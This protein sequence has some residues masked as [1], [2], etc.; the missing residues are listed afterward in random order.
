MKKYLILS[1]F[2]LKISL[3]FAQ[4]HRE[5]FVEDFSTDTN[6]W[7]CGVDQNVITSIHDGYY[8]IQGVTNGQGWEWA[9]EF[10]PYSYSNFN[11]QASFTKLGGKGYY[12]MSFGHKDYKYYFIIGEN[13]T[14]TILKRINNYTST[15]KLWTASVSIRELRGA[16]NDLS[17]RRKD[18]KL[19]FYINNNAVCSIIDEHF[20][21]DEIGFKISKNISVKVAE[22][23]VAT[24]PLLFYDLF[25]DNASQWPVSSDESD[26]SIVD[27]DVYTLKGKQQSSVLEKS[28]P[29]ELN[30]KYNFSIQTAIRRVSGD[31]SY[32]MVYGGEGKSRNLFVLSSSGSFMIVKSDKQNTVNLKAWTKSDAIKQN[33][34]AINVLKIEKENDKLR[35]YINNHKVHTMNYQAFFGRNIGYRVQRKQEIEVDYLKIS[36]EAKGFYELA[37]KASANNNFEKALECLDCAISLEFNPNFYFAR[38]DLYSRQGNYDQAI[39]DLNKAVKQ[40]LN[41]YSKVW[42]LGARADNYC[43]IDKY[44][45]AISDY[46]DA[47]ELTP[48]HKGITE[49][50][51]FAIRL[52]NKDS[53]ALEELA[54]RKKKLTTQVNQR[55]I[56][57]SKNQS[58]LSKIK[59]FKK[60][61]KPGGFSVNLPPILVISDISFSKNLLE[62][63]ETAQLNLTLKNTG[64][65]DAQD[66]SVYLSGFLN[67]LHFPEKTDL[68]VIPANGGTQTISIDVKGD[69]NLPTSEAIIKIEIIEPNFKVRI[70][71]K[72]LKFPT[73]EYHCP[74]LILAKY[75]IVENT[76]GDPNNKIDI[77]EMIDV[78]FAVQNVGYGDAK[79]VKVNILNNQKGVM[80]LGVEK[81]D[82]LLRQEPEFESIESGKYETI[83]YTYFVNSEFTDE[84]LIF[85]INTD[86]KNGK[87]GF[88]ESKSFSINKQLKESGFIRT[89][90][91]LNQKD[92]DIVIEDIPDFVVDV[93]TD[94]PVG[95]DSKPYTYALVIG[96]E[97]YETRQQTLEKEVNVPFALNDARVF[98]NYLNQTFGIP[99]ENINLLTNATGNQISQAVDR[100]SKLAKHSLGKAEIIFYYAGHG[101]PH[102]QTRE[103]Y[104]I[105]VDVSGSN[106]EYGIKLNEVYEK[107]SEYPSSRVLVFLDACFSG[108]AR[109]KPLIASRGIKVI[110]RKEYLKGNTLVFASSSGNQV[111]SAWQ[112]KQHGLFTYFLLK[113]IK[114][115][116]GKISFQELSEY[117]QEK[118]PLKAITINKPEQV[119]MVNSS[120]EIKD[121]WREW[122]LN[123]IEE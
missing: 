101:L 23:K 114:E 49:R 99:K 41:I 97:D 4:E 67:G 48:N 107:L 43:R 92:K 100:L 79:K 72:Q 3:S 19:K 68:P 17:I 74:D 58:N 83:T 31:G 73:R 26:E 98:S 94:I 1:I 102:Q 122:K 57:D 10:V 65:G 88:S 34:G 11:L 33:D 71:G 56:A 45:K 82:Q 77:N 110:P 89:V 84:D 91:Q 35:F 86:E 66:V 15:L 30:P 64:P 37:R 20:I 7:F 32:G 21:G 90:A 52:K 103:P 24:E 44:D 59:Q 78:K 85:T 18:D 6:G 27:R 60:T 42:A 55:K 117:L 112:E 81:D 63:E 13:N 9:K 62:A 38:A 123:A 115:T 121:I 93:D 95:V 53:K 106:I 104:L 118:I 47:L 119:P 76:S 109:N 80:L 116:E 46:N 5:I 14:Y 120:L 54:L 70:Q 12:G 22:Y 105:P 75:A 50:R 36:T 108:G 96:N 39:I 51:N 113:K 111:S 28:I 25:S 69:M 87:F 40:S 2:L 61:A 16:T 8:H 29:I